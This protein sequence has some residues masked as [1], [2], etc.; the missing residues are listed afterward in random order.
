MDASTNSGQFSIHCHDVSFLIA[1]TGWLLWFPY[2]HFQKC[3]FFVFAQSEDRLRKQRFNFHFIVALISEQLTSE[4]IKKSWSQNLGAT[5]VADSTYYPDNN[6]SFCLFLLPFFFFNY[7]KDLSLRSPS[8]VNET[9][10]H[11]LIS[12]NSP[13]CLKKAFHRYFTCSFQ[14]FVN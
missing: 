9:V 5:R 12:Y 13:C 4:K 11:L 1:G 7:H 3:L 2:T 10:W 6:E 14:L 8:Y